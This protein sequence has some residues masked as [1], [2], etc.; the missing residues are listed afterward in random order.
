MFSRLCAFPL[1]IKT[2]VVVSHLAHLPHTM[3]ESVFLL[4][5]AVEDEEVDVRR[6]EDNPPTPPFPVNFLFPSIL[7]LLHCG[8]VFL[9]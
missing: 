1:F 5:L 3:T 2:V 8:R 6:A 9:T 4:L 7:L